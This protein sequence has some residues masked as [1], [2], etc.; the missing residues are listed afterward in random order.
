LLNAIDAAKWF[1]LNNTDVT[2]NNLDGNIK[3]QKLLYYSQAMNLVVYNK[4]PLFTDNIEAWE[5]GPVISSVY[6]YY[7]YNNLVKDTLCGSNIDL[8]DIDKRILKIINLIYGN[9]TGKQLSELTHRELPWASLRT[10][11]KQRLNP[12]IAE[13]V[14]FDYYQPLKEIYV[15]YQNQDI[16]DFISDHINGNIFTYKKSELELTDELINELWTIGEDITDCS[17]FVY[18]EDN[19]LVV[20]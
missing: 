20:Y 3:L 4:T 12:V 18:F 14:L 19:E 15:S 13:D 10:Q 11:I 5:R 1:I 17:Y 8:G 7:R 16:D 6:T 9:K 2:S